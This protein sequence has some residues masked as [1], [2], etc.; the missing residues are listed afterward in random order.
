MGKEAAYVHD[1]RACF[2]GSANFA[3]EKIRS[4]AAEDHR[5]SEV[6]D[7]VDDVIGGAHFF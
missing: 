5:R 3:C 7:E 1:R 6:P 2:G 4:S